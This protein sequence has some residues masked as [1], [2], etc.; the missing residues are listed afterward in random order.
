MLGLAFLPSPRW[1]SSA[2][3]LNPLEGGRFCGNT[4]LQV[5]S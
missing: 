2:G 1:L 5:R 3:G 4:M